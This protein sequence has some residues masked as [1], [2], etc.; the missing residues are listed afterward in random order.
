MTNT[1]IANHLLLASGSP[2]RA[3]L[4]TQIGVPFSQFI[5]S[6]AEQ[7]QRTESPQDYIQRLAHDKAEAGLLAASTP[8][9][10][11]ALGV[12]TVVLAGETVLEKPRDYSNFESMMLALSGVEHSTLSAICLRSKKRQF[13]RLVETRVRFRHLSRV[14]IQAYWRTGEPV[15]KAGGYGIQGMGAALVESI[16]GSYSNVVGLPLEALVPMLEHAGIP[17]WQGTRL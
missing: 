3:Q 17:Y 2:R 1:S 16:S 4:L 12:D 5:P 7:R 6:V 9:E 11:W 8:P 10:L 13:S 15:D 14:Q